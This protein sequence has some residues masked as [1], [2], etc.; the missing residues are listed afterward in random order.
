MKAHEHG[1][2][3]MAKRTSQHLVALE[4]WE[5]G[6]A[7]TRRSADGNAFPNS[8]FRAAEKSCTRCRA[9]WK[10][11]RAELRASGVKYRQ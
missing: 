2:Q 6:L 8:G 7:I 10:G 5:G 4:L 1:T 9:L 3:E 11:I